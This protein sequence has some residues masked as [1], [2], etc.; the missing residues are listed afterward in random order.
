[1]IFPIRDEHGT[2]RGFAGRLLSGDGP[3]YLNTP[4]TELYQKRSLLYGLHLAYQPILDAG[5]AVVVEGYTDAIA[6]HQA[7]L[8]NVVATGGTALTEEHLK[9]LARI[10]S[11]VTLAFD[12]DHAGR[13]A[14]EGAAELDRAH[15]GIRLHVARLPEG[16][17]PPD[18]LANG[19]RHSLEGAIANAARLEHHLI[20]QIVEL[21]NLD[22]PEAMARA[23]RAARSVL[24]SATDI[25]VRTQA[26]EYLATS[27]GRHV[28]I[29]AAY[30]EETSPHRTLKRQRGTGRSLA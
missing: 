27:V 23:I 14:A 16:L 9:T 17:D 26:T 7:G 8:T 5:T 22:E 18:L 15:H 19:R 25:E 11:K 1:V 3:K 6:A 13:K 4:E 10:T 2:P 20:D 21:R 24:F 28:A 29:V 12:S 30:L